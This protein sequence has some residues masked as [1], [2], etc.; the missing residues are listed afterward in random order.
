MASPLIYL[1]RTVFFIMMIIQGVF[2]ASYPVK[3]EHEIGWYGLLFLYLPDLLV[4]SCILVKDGKIR[5]F[6]LVWGLYTWLT[7]DHAPL[8]P[9]LLADAGKEGMIHFLIGSHV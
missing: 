6:F 7:C 8:S 9:T 4:W 5:C 3:Y 1:G 2:F